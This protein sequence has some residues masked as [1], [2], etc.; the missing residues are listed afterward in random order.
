MNFA[1]A[2][3]DI[4]DGTRHEGIIINT[5]YCPVTGRWNVLIA[6]K[7]ASFHSFF[8]DSPG[9]QCIALRTEIKKGQNNE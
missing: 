1:A 3:E 6:T 2:H 5:A 7:S 9:A 4:V 8:A